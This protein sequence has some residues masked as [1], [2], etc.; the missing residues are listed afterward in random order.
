M[1]PV[2]K[3]NTLYREHYN[4]TFILS[5]DIL[6]LWIDRYTSVDP[7]RH[8]IHRPCNS[9]YFPVEYTA[10]II[11]IQRDRTFNTTH[12]NCQFW[13][14]IVTETETTI[15]NK[16]DKVN[17]QLNNV[18]IFLF[19]WCWSWAHFMQDV[20]PSLVSA[21]S[22]LNEHPDYKIMLIANDF[23]CI[24]PELLDIS[25]PIIQI[26]HHVLPFNITGQCKTIIFESKEELALQNIIANIRDYKYYAQTNTL[27]RTNLLRMFP[28]LDNAPNK[29]YFIYLSREGSNRAIKN[30]NEIRK[31]DERIIV[32][33]LNEKPMPLYER[34]KL[35]YNASLIIA[36]HGGA[37]YHVL[38]CK[39]G[40]PFIEIYSASNYIN[41]EHIAMGIPLQYFPIMVNTLQHHHEQKY[42]HVNVNEIKRIINYIDRVNNSTT[43]KYTKTIYFDPSMNGLGDCIVGATS[44]LVLSQIMNAN[45]RILNGKIK[46][47]KYFNIPTEYWADNVPNDAVHITYWYNTDKDNIEHI[48][49]N[50]ANNIVIK[51][52]QNFGRFLYRNTNYNWRISIPE[53]EVVYYMMK[54]ILKPYDRLLNIFNDLHSKLDMTNAICIHVRCGDV[55]GDNE[56][57]GNRINIPDT[58]LNFIKCVKHIRKNN[59]PIIL[60]SDNVDRVIPIF[61]EHDLSCQ[62]IPGIPA[63]SYNS[64]N[65]DYD[66]IILDLLTFG[67]CKELIISYWSNFGRIGA[68]RALKDPWITKA[69]IC[70]NTFCFN[71]D[72]NDCDF[73]KAKLGELLSKEV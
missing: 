42:Y 7:E 19:E 69:V 2:S 40:T 50:N 5:E 24:I 56:S 8:V 43:N 39:P 72:I 16:D 14:P 11:K 73:R 4:N 6:K 9:E 44:C 20:V 38:A 53:S 18:C 71:V 33:N 47:N 25:N 23:T 62:I 35:F 26:D 49:N 29:P 67:A 12:F 27:I 32:F 17:A 46:M 68:L 36:P 55:W 51:S 1:D 59:E 64:T 48:V 58:I 54:N 61:K 28:E 52:C 66:K 31:L 65:I 60:I 45:F 70:D 13:T 3:Y 15:D 63:H 22:F 57:L 21:K 37:V 10:N 30:D 41:I 34:F